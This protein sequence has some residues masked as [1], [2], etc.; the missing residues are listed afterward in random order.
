MMKC[1]LCQSEKRLIWGPSSDRPKLEDVDTGNWI[2][3]EKCPECGAQ[4]VES[5][6][7][8][9]ASFPYRVRWY[10]SA[11]EWRQLHDLDNG[12]A[13]HEWLKERIRLLWHK[14]PKEERNQIDYH[15]KRSYGHNPIDMKPSNNEQLRRIVLMIEQTNALDR[16]TARRD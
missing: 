2:A 6:Y 12:M 11:T 15:R 5:P 4:W 9:Y 1:N 13:L 14:L 16:A 10:G 3:L 7:E 8:P